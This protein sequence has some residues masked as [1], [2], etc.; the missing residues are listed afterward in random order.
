MIFR[1]KFHQAHEAGA[2]ERVEEREQVVT[3]YPK[4]EAIPC[5]TVKTRPRAGARRAWAIG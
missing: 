2:D 5:P 4:S 3:R 1:L